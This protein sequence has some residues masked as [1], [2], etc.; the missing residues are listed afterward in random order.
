MGTETDGSGIV[1]QQGLNSDTSDYNA[2]EFQIEQAFGRISTMR[3][4]KI[5]GVQNNGGLSPVGLVSVKPMVNIVNGLLGDS[6]QHG[7]IYNVP[8]VRIQGGKNAII[9]DPVV[10]DI[11]FVVCADR[12]SSAVKSTK[13][14]ANPG[15]SRRFSLSDGIYVGGV[16]NDTP[17]QYIQFNETGV[18]IA[19]KNGNKLVSSSTGW[20][21]TGQVKFDGLAVMSAG[22]QL[23]GNILGVGGARYTG[24][25]DTSGTITSGLIGLAS[26]H[27]TAQGA[28]AATTAAQA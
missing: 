9:I 22:M 4:V 13:N 26:H 5:M 15:S 23:S 17:E 7:T 14:F 8:Y 10:G 11:G 25:F 20:E 6:Q 12:D 27:H 16:L 19:D 28:T 24:N 2:I 21:F 1:G 3:L 18:T